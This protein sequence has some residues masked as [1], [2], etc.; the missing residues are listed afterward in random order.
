MRSNKGWPVIAMAALMLAHMPLLAQR[1]A[2]ALK[3]NILAHLDPEYPHQIQVSVQEPGLVTL[4][5]AVKSYW[6]CRHVYAI[7]AKIPGVQEIKNQV[8]VEAEVRP[9]DVIKDEIVKY[10]KMVKSIDDPDRIAVAVSNGLVILRGTVDS[11]KEANIVED[12]ASWH[13]GVKSVANEIRVLPPGEVDSDANLTGVLRDLITREF[14]FEH[15]MVQ[16][17][18]TGGKALLTGTV[19][20]LWA[21][22]QIE[23]EVHRIQGIASVDNQIRIHSAS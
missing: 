13:P 21:S 20:W 23:K 5:G 18:V 22:K 9:D 2:P 4:K 11:A 12:V 16:V 15:N 14:P 8:L 19:S 1:P 6:D 3:A 17:E 10:L 7:T